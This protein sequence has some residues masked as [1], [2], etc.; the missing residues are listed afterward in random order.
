MHL[1]DLY[2]LSRDAVSAWIDDHASSR[3]AALA[4]YT[5]FSMAPLLLI[6]TSVA[7]LLFGAEAARDEIV[8][9][10]RSVIGDAGADAVHQVLESATGPPMAA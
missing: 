8:G 1:K 9:Q 2:T 6:V 3:G 5:L 4:Y 10:L 7:G